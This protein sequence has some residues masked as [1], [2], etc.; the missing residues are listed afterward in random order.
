MIPIENLPVVDL[1]SAFEEV[2]EYWSPKVVARVNDQYVKLA[3]LKG[4]FTWHSHEHEDEMFFV[5]RGQ[6]DIQYE[7]GRVVSLNSG[8]LH[9]VPR[10][11]L[12][13]PFAE[14]E[15]WIMLIETVTTLHTGNLETPYTKSIAQQLA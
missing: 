13:N 6:L 5:V 11:V 14:Q 3:K 8:A 9:V 7:G 4:E 1:L 10:G 15:C 12:H 2:T